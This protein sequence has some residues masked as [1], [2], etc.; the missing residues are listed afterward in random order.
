MLL[1]MTIALTH[2]ANVPPTLCRGAQ[3]LSRHKLIVPV[4]YVTGSPAVK[5]DYKRVSN[6]LAY[7]PEHKIKPV[8]P[9]FL[10]LFGA[11]VFV[12]PIQ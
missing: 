2:N 11:I 12:V 10:A 5:R 8:F 9:H 3:N 1:L 7:T 6:M 4:P